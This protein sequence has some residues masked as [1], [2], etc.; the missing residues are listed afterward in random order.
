MESLLITLPQDIILAKGLGATSTI[1]T[2]VNI[3]TGTPIIKEP[4]VAYIDAK[5]IGNIP[6]LFEDGIHSF[7]VKKLINEYP[8]DTKGINPL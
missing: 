2:A 6:Y 3:P 8:L 7:P 5:I 4:N 1:K